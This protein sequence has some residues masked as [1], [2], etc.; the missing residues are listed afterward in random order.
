M[1]VESVQ[2]STKFDLMPNTYAK[3]YDMQNMY[4]IRFVPWRS[5]HRVPL[6]NSRS[7]FESRQGVREGFLGRTQHCCCAKSN[8]IDCLFDLY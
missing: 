3:I 8:N 4:V 1:S 2:M 5:G 6:R 7:R